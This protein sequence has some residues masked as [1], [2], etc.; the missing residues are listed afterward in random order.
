V[1]ARLTGA[2]PAAVRAAAVHATSPAELL[3][4]EEIVAGL[5]RVMGIEGADHG[6]TGQA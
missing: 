5:A 3:A 2:D 6:W 1:V 4:A